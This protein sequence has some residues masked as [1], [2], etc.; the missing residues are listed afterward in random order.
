MSLSLKC[1]LLECLTLKS[2]VSTDALNSL[3]NISNKF[4]LEIR[5][6]PPIF[7]ETSLY[8]HMPL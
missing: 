4:W 8:T 1:I 2:S 6:E 7:S 3:K 5:T